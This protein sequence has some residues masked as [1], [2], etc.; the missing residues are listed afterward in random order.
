M[1]DYPLHFYLIFFWFEEII[2]S[3]L[4]LLPLQN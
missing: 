2:L 4:F 3:K 1:N